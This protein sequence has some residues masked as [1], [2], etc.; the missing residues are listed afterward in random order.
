[1]RMQDEGWPGASRIEGGRTS[2]PTRDDRLQT[3]DQRGTPNGSQ[4]WLTAVK[5]RWNTRG[6][7]S[8]ARRSLSAA[9]LDAAKA[10]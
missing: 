9:T 10:Q 5:L 3:T 6:R 2:G 7:R 1:M 8:G 4:H